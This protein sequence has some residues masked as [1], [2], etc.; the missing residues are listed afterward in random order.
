MTTKE[1]ERKALEKIRKIIAEL[2]TDSYVGT[3]FN[4]C[5]EWAEKNIENDFANDPKEMLATARD[6][7]EQY[8]AEAEKQ[9]RRA[10]EFEKIAAEQTGRFQK[11]VDKLNENLERAHDQTAEAT[12]T[13]MEYWNGWQASKQK[14]EEA[15]DTIIK[16]KAKLY[17]MMTA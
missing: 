1:Q 12:N 6:H 15:E 16:L 10:E 14:L 3:A 5:F 11:Q 2:G 4:G 17:D 9:T 13:A 7:A 8:K